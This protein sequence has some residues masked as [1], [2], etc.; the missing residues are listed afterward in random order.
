MLK[1]AIF[2]TLLAFGAFAQANNII[3]T[4]APIQYKAD[5]GVVGEWVKSGVEEGPWEVIATSCA[6]WSPE[7]DAI[8]AGLSFTQSGAT[9]SQTESRT[10]TDILTNSVT[11]DARL[12]ETS[13]TEDR[14]VNVA[15]MTRTMSGTATVFNSNVTAG[16][17]VVGSD[18]LVG[19]YA[20]TNTGVN[21]GTKL[22]NE[23]GDRVLFYAYKYGADTVCQLRFAVTGPNGW[24]PGLGN[25]AANAKKFL[26]RYSKI[27]MRDVNGNILLSANLGALASSTGTE[28]GAMRAGTVACSSI[29]TLYNA[30]TTIKSVRAEF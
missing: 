25:P 26:D 24:Q 9:C 16:R 11:G 7:P 13:T 2:M 19:M 27:T 22:T 3:R 10:L 14:V 15:S 18:T 6:S 21:I 8:E 12:A 20:R 29:N 17:A 1:Q 5:S 23:Y 28:G 30:P 4:P